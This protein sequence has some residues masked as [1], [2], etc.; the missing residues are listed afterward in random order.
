MKNTVILKW[1]PAISSYRMIDFLDDIVQNNTKSDWSIR[2]YEKVRKGDRFY[3]LKVGQGATGIVMRGEITSD[4]DGDDWSQQGCK[5][6]YS[7][8]KAEIMINPDTF[9]LLTGEMLQDNIPG[10]DWSG[11]HSGMVLDEKQSAVLEQ[12]WKA[13]L[14]RS[15]AEFQ[16]R[17]ELLD[18]RAM[19]NDQLYLEL[20]LQNELFEIVNY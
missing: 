9:A 10:F 3:M 18:R 16:S 5:R 20:E 6:Y 8:Y 13:Y 15:K 14:Q 2:E 19:L 7:N 17:I 11:G 12:M 1:N 4:P